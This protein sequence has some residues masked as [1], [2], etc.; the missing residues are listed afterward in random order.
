MIPADH[1]EDVIQS[2]I[3]FLR[4]ITEA[5]GNDEGMQLWENIAKIL[6][7]DVKGQIFFALLTG[8]YNGIINIHSSV[9]NANKVWR[10]KALRAVANLSL[11]E[12]KELCD[13]LDSGKAIKLNVDPKTRNSALSEL[14]NAGFHV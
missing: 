9:P 11:K 5:Y 13:T 2:G 7:P 10:I 4:S 14:R 3:N 1:K 8:Q 12:A 6:D